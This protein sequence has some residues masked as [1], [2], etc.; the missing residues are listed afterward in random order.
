MIQNIFISGNQST[1]SKISHAILSFI[2]KTNQPFKIVESDGFRELMRATAP[3]YYKIPDQRTIIR[4]FEDK[5]ESLSNIVK[6]ELKN[7][8]GICFT[9]DTWIEKN[10]PKIVVG[11]TVHYIIDE[12]YKSVTIGVDMFTSRDTAQDIEEKLKSII[13]KWNIQNQDILAIVTNNGTNVKTILQMNS[14]GIIQERCVAAICTIAD[15]IRKAIDK[16]FGTEKVLPCFAYVLNVIPSTIIERITEHDIIYQLINK[17]KDIVIFFQRSVHADEKLKLLTNRRLILGDIT[18]WNSCYA[19]L[20]QF[21][22]IADKVSDILQKSREPP[23]LTKSE[24][25]I[26]IDFI[27]LLE[28]FSLANDIISKGKYFPGSKIIPLVNELKNQLQELKPKTD[29]GLSLKER[30]LKEFDNRFEHIEKSSLLGMATLLDPRFKKL[31]FRSISNTWNNIRWVANRLNSLVNNNT[32]TGTKS[33]WDYIDTSKLKKA[34]SKDINDIPEELQ[35]YVDSNVID[36]GINP[37]EFWE[38][39]QQSPLSKI[40][41]RHLTLIATTVR[42]ER[43]KNRIHYGNF[44]FK[45]LLFLDSLTVENKCY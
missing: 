38:K 12:N 21:V 14:G 40:A 34:S 42:L 6:D 19:M 20:Q 37:I 5:Y 2:T 27:D 11:L 32:N 3:S 45:Q 43:T 30:L 26:I 29:P 1:A 16:F 22:S 25:S 15:N 36:K 7:A 4:M 39:Q 13:S 23:M 33:F 35:R 18:Q 28:P 10:N 24:L 31:H 9:T 44:H 17:V 8:N 41:I